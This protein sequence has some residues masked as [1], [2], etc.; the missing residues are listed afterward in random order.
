MKELKTWQ[1]N[2]EE[3]LKKSHTNSSTLSDYQ[4]IEGLSA[5][6]T[7]V[8]WDTAPISPTKPFHE[9]L[10]LKLSEDPGPPQHTSTLPK[11]PFL[12]KGTGLERFK[13]NNRPLPRRKSRRISNEGTPLRAPDVSIQAKGAWGPTEAIQKINHFA[14]R[15]LVSFFLILT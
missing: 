7:T 3:L 5:F 4:T 2:H 6:D 10:E 14:S 11:R 12:K 1:E 8:D 9:V 15:T 13:M